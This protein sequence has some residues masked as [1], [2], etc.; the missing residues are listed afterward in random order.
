LRQNEELF[1]YLPGEEKVT[2]L[3]S[4]LSDVDLLV[5]LGYDLRFCCGLDIEVS[6]VRTFSVGQELTRE[7]IKR[8]V[9]ASM[10]ERN[11]KRVGR[12][13]RVEGGELTSEMFMRAALCRFDLITAARPKESPQQFACTKERA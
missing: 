6:T 8:V 10:V 5:G 4:F 1:I 2:S 3:H 7:L 13:K 9:N 12:I 11:N